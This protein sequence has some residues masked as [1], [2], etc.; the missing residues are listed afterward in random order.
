MSPTINC[1]SLTSSPPPPHQISAQNT[2]NQSPNHQIYQPIGNL[3][4]ISYSNYYN[5]DI[6]YTHYQTTPEYIPLLNTDISYTSIGSERNN[7]TVYQDVGTLE[8]NNTYEEN[9]TIQQQPESPP[10]SESSTPRHE[11]NSQNQI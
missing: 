4:N 11:W 8:K 1:W 9:S 2:P 10:E 3:T 7:S 6:T 5:Q